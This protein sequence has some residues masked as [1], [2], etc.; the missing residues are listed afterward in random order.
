MQPFTTLTGIA[1][2]LLQPNV[3]TEVIIRVNRLIEHDPDK[4]GP[5]CF[6]S[7]RYRVDGSE[8]LDFVLN[9]PSY[10]GAQ[11]LLCGE[12]FGCGSSRE[13]AVWS[14]LDFGVRCVIAASFSDIFYENC[15]QNGLLPVKVSP[16]LV[17][18]LAREL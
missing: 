1:A 3:D 5:Y 8:N 14:L 15:L 4:L 16:D 18:S 2:P 17:Q 11:I 12:N 7:L 13:A 10:R 6:E 9:A